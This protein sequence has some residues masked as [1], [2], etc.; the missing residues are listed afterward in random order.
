MLLVSF[1]ASPLLLQRELKLPSGRKDHHRHCSL[2]RIR[3]KKRKQLSLCFLF[4]VNEQIHFFEK[5]GDFYRFFDVQ[6]FSFPF[7][8]LPLV[9]EITVMAAAAAASSVKQR[10]AAAAATVATTCMC[11]V[12]LLRYSLRV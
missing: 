5:F 11:M 3:N 10:Q 6:N 8:P 9:A 4:F 1:S 7:F 12:L 2:Y